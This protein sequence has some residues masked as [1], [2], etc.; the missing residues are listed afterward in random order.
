MLQDLGPLPALWREL[1]EEGQLNTALALGTVF[2]EK[3]KGRNMQPGETAEVRLPSAAGGTW[4]WT[5]RLLHRAGS[6]EASPFIWLGDEEAGDRTL[7]V[8]FGP[9]RKKRQF[10]KIW[11]A[12]TH[13]V[14]DILP[15]GAEAGGSGSHTVLVSSYIKN[16]LDKLWGHFGFGQQLAEAAAGHPRHRILFAG[17]SHGAALA[18]AA[19]LRFALLQPEREVCAV[20]WNGYKWT[21][22]AGSALAGQAL[23]HRLLPLVLSRC[24]PGEQR[25]WDSVV[26][27]PAGF[28]A[29]PGV[30]L[31]DVDCGI[32]LPCVLGHASLGPDFAARMA[33]LHFAKTALKAMEAAMTL[34]SSLRLARLEAAGSGD[35][36]PSPLARAMSWEGTGSCEVMAH[37]STMLEGQQ[38]L[39]D[40]GFATPE[41][42]SDEDDDDDSRE[43]ER[44]DRFTTCVAGAASQAVVPA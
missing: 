17:I 37:R 29:M 19:A 15:P 34:A 4:L 33:E 3:Y 28:A 1:L 6:R 5:T 9:L 26:E 22:A 10:L 12:G 40:S 23:G 2:S 43:G 35:A 7:Y 42:A 18:Q 21:D 24:E 8:T 13:L 44:V 39:E 31:V 25:R 27:F 30:M 11:S 41:D 14:E 20:T 36:S 38:V 32:F 16:K